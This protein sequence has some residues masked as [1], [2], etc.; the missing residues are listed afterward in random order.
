M[1][2]IDS[3]PVNSIPVHGGGFEDRHPGSKFIFP[4]LGIAIETK[5]VALECYLGSV[6]IFPL[7]GIRRTCADL[8]TEVVVLDRYL[9]GPSSGIRRTYAAIK[10]RLLAATLPISAL[11]ASAILAVLIQL[12]AGTTLRGVYSDGAFYATRLAAHLSILHPGRVMSNFIVGWPVVAA[13]HLG[14]QTPYSV[15]LVWSIVSNLLPGLIMLLCLPTLP[16]GER[17][18]FIFPAFIYFAGTLSAQFNSDAEGLV[19]TSYFWL[20]LCLITFGRLTNLRLALIALLSVGTLDLHEQ[21]LFLGPILVVSCAIRLRQEPLL[22]PRIVLLVAALC[23]LASIV[24]AVHYILYPASID[25]RDSFIASIP[26]FRWL[27]Q[28]GAGWNLPCLLGIL[29]VPCI[30]LTILR[31]AW[32]GTATWIFAASSIPLALAAFWLDWLTVPYTQ[33]AARHN[34]AL[35]SL[36][37]A[38]LFLHARAHPQLFTAMTTRPVRGIVIILGLTVSLWH[39]AATEQWSAF[40]TDFSNILRS[41]DG[42]IAGDT[43]FAPP[44]SRQAELAKKMFWSWTYPDLSLVALPRSCINSVMDSPSWVGSS[45]Y[46]LSNLATM[47]AIPG[48]T[49]TYLLPPDQQHSA[50]PQLDAARVATI[51]SNKYDAELA[52]VLPVYRSFGNSM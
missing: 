44:G 11:A 41:R 3:V 30:L 27:Y 22:L 2:R 16:A 13:I 49:Y 32:G 46:T 23:S 25:D 5:L 12:Y 50:C 1:H 29:A 6:L 17:H 48:I 33:Y 28:R 15:A 10:T 19:A 21:M 9:G 40:L 14:V 51:S 36:P 31:P 38:A 8:K 42:I 4:L 43:A 45:P 47:P 34:G 52:H 18:F 20:L 35:M 37:L 7:L 26:A 24:I 39:V